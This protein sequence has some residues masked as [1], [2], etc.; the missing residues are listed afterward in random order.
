MTINE[1]AAVLG[2]TRATIYNRQASGELPTGQ[3][4]TIALWQAEKLETEAAKIRE[5][6]KAFTSNGSATT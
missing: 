1:L 6:V 3:P 5:L 2:V 4:E